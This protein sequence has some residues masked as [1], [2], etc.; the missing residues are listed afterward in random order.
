MHPVR[1]AFAGLAVYALVTACGAL[2]EPQANAESG[3]VYADEPCIDDVTGKLASHEFPGRSA[4]ELYLV[5][6]VCHT[7]TPLRFGS[8]DYPDF[9]PG[10][11]IHIRDG[12]VALT[13]LGV[14]ESVT[15]VLP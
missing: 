10:N 1:H 11:S 3:P 9:T 2:A 14:C 5:R 7:R 6:A 4:R 12:A 15:F 8:A 13:C